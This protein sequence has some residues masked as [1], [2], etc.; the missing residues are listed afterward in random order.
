MR[1]WGKDQESESA[2]WTRAQSAGVK[3][4]CLGRARS[5]GKTSSRSYT[6]EGEVLVSSSDSLTRFLFVRLFVFFLKQLVW[7]IPFP[8]CL[9]IAW[10]MDM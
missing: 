7:S 10:V 9:G 6:S 5:P 4:G 3:K 8:G 2:V 1:V